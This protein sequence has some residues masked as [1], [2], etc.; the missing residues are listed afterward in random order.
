MA[1]NR[2]DERRPL[3]S[4]AAA[5][6]T[7]AFPSA[8]PPEYNSRPGSS[9]GP[10]E[11]FVNQAD[12]DE[13][14][15]PYSSVAGTGVPAINCRV[16]QTMINLNGKTSQHVVKCNVCNEATPIKQAPPGKKYVRC[17][18]NCLLI[19]KATSRRVACPRENC[20]L[21]MVLESA[22][23]NNQPSFQPGTAR[24]VCAYCTEPFLFNIL[25]KALARCPHCRKI[26][27]V[28]R[29]FLR[30][31]RVIFLT[32]ALS[33]LISGILVVVFTHTYAKARGGLY[34]LYTILFLL[35]IFTCARAIYY[36]T[37]RVSSIEGPPAA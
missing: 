25:N 28:G 7:G 22:P 14:P 10:H 27:S 35:F 37:I 15:P 5:T 19:C 31:R 17:K 9:L 33:F 2:E 26:S 30:S 6:A 21:I 8:P 4:P 24:V 20:K 34:A 13:L 11:V 12:A 36:L 32:L 18:C 1:S 3:L 29:A 16:C 23:G